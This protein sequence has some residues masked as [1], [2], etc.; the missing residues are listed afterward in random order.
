M[1]VSHYAF[2][3][4]VFWLLAG[5]MLHVQSSSPFKLAQVDVWRQYL[6]QVEF[7]ED[8]NRTDEPHECQAME[9][10]RQ[11]EVLRDYSEPRRH[12]RPNQLHTPCLR[13]VVNQVL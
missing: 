7:K 3:A 13:Y 2:R 4:C 10:V 11:D 8:F 12:M 1:A 6:E 5:R 9:D